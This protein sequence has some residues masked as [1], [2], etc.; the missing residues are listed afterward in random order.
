M[1]R[2]CG[3]FLNHIEETLFASETFV[4]KAVFRIE[5]KQNQSGKRSSK[6]KVKETKDIR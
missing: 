6:E 2:K 4:K 1:W 5:R 3:L